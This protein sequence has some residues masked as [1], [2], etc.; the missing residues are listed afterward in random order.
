MVMVTSPHQENPH[1][2]TWA[3]KRCSILT[4]R[5]FAPCHDE[6]PCQRFYDWCIFDACGYVLGC[7]HLRVGVPE[8]P[9][10]PCPGHHP[11]V[12]CL[13]L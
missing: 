9:A 8:P 3:R 11:A 6:V 12:P 2:A 7:G 5:L 10:C 1:R 13:Q 4:Q